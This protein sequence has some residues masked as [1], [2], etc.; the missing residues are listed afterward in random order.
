MKG[1]RLKI[2]IRG[3]ILRT[4]SGM[5]FLALSLRFGTRF[6]DATHAR[7]FRGYVAYARKCVRECVGT[8]NGWLARRPLK[9]SV[10]YAGIGRITGAL[11]PS[12]IP[13]LLNP[14][15]ALRISL[16]KTPYKFL[17]GFFLTARANGPCVHVARGMW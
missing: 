17:G 7:Y 12:N 13:L 4:K 10:D 14:N 5:R 16:N 3:D 9:R 8:H 15:A 6:L 1:S 2:G 11:V